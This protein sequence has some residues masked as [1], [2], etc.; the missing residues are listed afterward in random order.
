MKV[1]VTGASGYLGKN[2]TKELLNRDVNVPIIRNKEK[3]EDSANCLI[4]DLCNKEK[5]FKKLKEFLPD[6]VV[7]CAA[8][9]PK[10]SNKKEE[11]LSLQNNVNA[12]KNLYQLWEILV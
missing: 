4:S 3:Y 6:V 12:T 8:F 2:L 7:H 10:Y 1:C 5:L 9:I 11:F